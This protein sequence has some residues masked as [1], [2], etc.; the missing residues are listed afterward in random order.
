MEKL[1]GGGHQTGA[2][3]QVQESPEE[4]IAKAVAIMREE[5]QL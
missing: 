1:G 5:H 4:A 2:A 3:A